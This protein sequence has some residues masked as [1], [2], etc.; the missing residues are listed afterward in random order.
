MWFEVQIFLV[1][2]VRSGSLYRICSF[3]AGRIGRRAFR[4]ICRVDRVLGC[5]KW[6]GV[7]WR[8]DL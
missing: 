6:L 2:G 5:G 7:E 4:V 1:L 8:G 3:R